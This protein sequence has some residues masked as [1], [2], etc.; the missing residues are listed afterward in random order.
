MKRTWFT[1]G[2]LI[3]ALGFMVGCGGAPDRGAATTELISSHQAVAAA[4]AIYGGAAATFGQERAKLVSGAGEASQSVWDVSF[5]ASEGEVHALVDA[6]SGDVTSTESVTTSCNPQ[7]KPHCGPGRA[8]H[9]CG[10]DGG[11]SCFFCK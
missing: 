4:E 10:L 11:W 1:V 6:Q 3:G 7:T 9:C 2:S 8:V 5:V